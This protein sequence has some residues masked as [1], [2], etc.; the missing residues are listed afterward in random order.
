[1]GVVATALLLLVGLAL[2]KL[3]E[4]SRTTRRN[5]L[6]CQQ[7]LQQIG[8]ALNDFVSEH[9]G[10]YPWQV[11]MAEGGSLEAVAGGQASPHFRCLT[12][13]VRNARVFL[14]PMDPIRHRGATILTLEDSAIS[15]FLNV[16]AQPQ[17]R[18]AILAGDRT[19]SPGP[20]T[21][22]GELTVTR[23]VDLQWAAPAPDEPGHQTYDTRE[24]T[25]NLL[26]SSGTLMETTSSQLRRVVRSLG[27]TPQHIILP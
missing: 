5:P 3:W 17:M 1:M 19:L 24:L 11:P 9:G 20:D 12:N 8:V 2:S 14:C 22:T 7:N 16:S 26:F 23:E 18:N 13:T 10:R 21:S 15:Y 4:T 27:S 25:G 6:Q